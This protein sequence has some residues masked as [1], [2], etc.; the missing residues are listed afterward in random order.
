VVFYYLDG[1]SVFKWLPDLFTDFYGKSRFRQVIPPED[2][3]QE[4]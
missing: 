1:I 2:A 4:R 3:E